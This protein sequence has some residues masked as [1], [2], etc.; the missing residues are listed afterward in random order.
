M[1]WSIYILIIANLLL[2]AWWY[3]PTDTVEQT[4][5]APPL[6]PGTE[7]LVL[8]EEYDPRALAESEQPAPET[9]PAAAA[10]ATTPEPPPEPLPDL[11]Q[12]PPEPEPEPVPEPQ[13]EPAAEPEPTPPPEPEQEAEPA[14]QPEPE[15]E[16]EPAIACLSVGPFADEAGANAVREQLNATGLDPQQRSESVQQPA[17][18]WVYL[19]A[20]PS[21]EARAIVEDL[22][23]RGVE[24][25]FVGR[26]NFI[27]LG[28]FSD[29]TT[30]ERRREEI[31]GYGYEPQLE[32]R[33]RTTSQYW[34][35]LEA[36]EPDLPTEA[37]WNDWLEQ[38]PDAGPQS[39]PCQ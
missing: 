39:K 27:S 33:F 7:R 36:P 19:S 10:D 11:V 38:Y 9:P 23:R 25:Y 6:P 29:R 34:L 18:F 35:D 2:F 17:G 32:Q 22:T 21:D 1:K 13:P 16:P 14:P 20:R 37:Q 5:P 30:A 4:P 8:L 12:A 3:P 26:Q 28:I 15:P 31:E 24:D